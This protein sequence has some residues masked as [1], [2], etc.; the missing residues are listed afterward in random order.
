M[1]RTV[2][3]RKDLI[4]AHYDVTTMQVIKNFTTDTKM[5]LPEKVDSQSRLHC[6]VLDMRIRIGYAYAIKHGVM[7]T[8]T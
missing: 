7:K 6:M 4:V 3:R 5:R 1:H 8:C 2:F